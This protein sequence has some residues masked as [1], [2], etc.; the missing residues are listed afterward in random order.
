M[1]LLTASGLAKSYG[2]QDVFS[3]VSLAIPRQGRIALVGSNGAGKTSLLRIMAGLDRQDAGQV[4]R[5]RGVRL[6]YLPQETRIAVAR[7]NDSTESLWDMCL[8]AL[9]DLRRQ[10]AEMARL[11]AAMT[12]PQRAED[13]MA[14]YGPLQEAFD[15]AGGYTYPARIRRVLRGLG[16]SE[17]EIAAPLSRLS[18]GE[19][20]RADLARLLLEDPDLL[21]L[22]EPT[23]HLDLQAIEWL[24]GW[25]EG[26]PG[27]AVIVSHDRYFLDHSVETVWELDG[28]KLVSYHG[29]YSAY[30]GQRAE[31]LR[32]QE[33][34]YRAQ[35]DLVRREQDYIRRNIA[36]Q[37][38]RQAQGRRTRLE[39][40]LQQQA[41]GRPAA[42]RNVRI[43]FAGAD[44]SGDVI[45]ETH[46]LA[47]G[48]AD[49]AEALF[50]VPDLVLSRG[51]CVALVGPN[52][53]GKTTFLKTLL[54]DIPPS[55]GTI[56]LGAGLKLG[57]F[58]QAH[59]LLQPDRTVVE[60]VLSA[61]PNWT[62]AQARD[63]LARFL[64]TGDSV[65]KQVEVL[66]GGERGRVAL[67]KLALEGANL[68]L[69]DE[70]TNHLDLPSQ[71]VLQIA[72]AEFPGTILLV[73]HDR[74][75]IDALATQIWDVSP[76]E[77]RLGVFV[78]GYAE[79]VAGREGRE[80]ANLPRPVSRRA[81]PTTRPGDRQERAELEAAETRIARLEA[82]LAD[83]G[84]ELDHAGVDVDK[85]RIL[86]QQYAAIERILND[87]F[88]AWE[89][90]AQRAQRAQRPA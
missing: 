74:Y 44:R 29:N 54:G 22:D 10:E 43:D 57:Y 75:L 90:L 46:G 78:G 83:V 16:F 60:E 73:S 80:A 52:G 20:T 55:A 21:L 37:N 8:G 5:A 68:L 36:G 3:G 18:G 24:E 70:P 51:E 47:V 49:A 64:F 38:S 62:R 77:H 87:E 42:E 26:W 53:A 19:R 66:S 61:A 30:A 34:E 2:A 25:L 17:G 14:R 72:L 13:A 12:D 23:N 65:D 15:R 59:E 31:R 58:A 84:R 9:P 40:M 85:V 67:A 11:E 82:E 39:R 81:R 50:D 71:E 35:Q 4:R 7:G 69:L 45:L 28:R 88:S 48:Y 41:V 6:G 56:R 89:R 33:G 79:F 32:L 27:A 86:G 63:F 1:S 76:E